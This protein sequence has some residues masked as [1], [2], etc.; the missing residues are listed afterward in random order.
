MAGGIGVDKCRNS[1]KG[2]LSP[3]HPETRA[4]AGAQHLDGKSDGKSL[5]GSGDTLRINSVEGSL[6]I[7]WEGIKI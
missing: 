7:E 5:R 3:N 6:M 2:Q 1:S 4:N